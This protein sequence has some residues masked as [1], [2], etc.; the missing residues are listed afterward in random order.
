MFFS[1]NDD[2]A[3]KYYN[4]SSLTG[5]YGRNREEDEEDW[6]MGKD[7]NIPS[8]SLSLKRTTSFGCVVEV[9]EGNDVAAKS[10]LIDGQPV[11]D[12][13]SSVVSGCRRITFEFL[14]KS[15]H[16]FLKRFIAFC[17]EALFYSDLINAFIA[18]F[19]ARLQ[20]RFHY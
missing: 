19:L 6:K 9:Y 14:I 5:A 2:E 13:A 3:V 12:L 18:P 7:E 17:S 1:V 4:G 11:S 20:R 10:L 16:A 8:A 15:N